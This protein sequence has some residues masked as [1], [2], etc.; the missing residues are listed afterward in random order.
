VYGDNVMSRTQVSEWHKWFLKGWEEVE[1]NKHPR[2]TWTSKTEEN[3]EKISG[4]VQK[5]GV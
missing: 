3:V 2:R 4:I 5:I 1:D